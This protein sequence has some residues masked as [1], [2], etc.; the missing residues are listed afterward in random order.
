MD[1]IAKYVSLPLYHNV[2]K[3]M[4]YFKEI[5]GWVQWDDQNN[6]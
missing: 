6:C 3:V 5:N 1:M 4:K 2:N